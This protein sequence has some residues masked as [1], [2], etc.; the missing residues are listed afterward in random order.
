MRCLPLILPSLPL[1]VFPYLAYIAACLIALAGPVAM[2]GYDGPVFLKVSFQNWS[3]QKE[4]KIIF[5]WPSVLGNVAIKSSKK[6][7]IHPK[8]YCV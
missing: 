2:A 5:R 6:Y 1:K 3:I 7:F 4:E 8:P